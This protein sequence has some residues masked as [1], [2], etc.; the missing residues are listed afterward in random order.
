MPL[1][2]LTD[3]PAAV[4]GEA[5]EGRGLIRHIGKIVDVYATTMVPKIGVVL[6]EAYT[7]CGSMVLSGLKGLGAASTY[8]WPIA[9]FAVEA[10]TLDYRKIYGRGIEQDAYESYLNRSRERVDAFGAAHSWTSQIV[11][12]IILPGETRKKII[13]ALRLTANK[14]ETLPERAKNHGTSPT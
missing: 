10:S 11:D 4:P 2:N 6:R 9:R 8:A 3:T 14:R 5:E 12:E 1:V 13:E 7:D